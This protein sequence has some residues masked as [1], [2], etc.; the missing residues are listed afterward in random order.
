MESLS[1]GNGF[2]AMSSY[3]IELEQG[4]NVL[5]VGFNRDQQADND[6]IVKDAV[7]RLSELIEAK[8]LQGG[9]L[10]K[11]NGPQSLPVA[12]VIAHKVAHLYG[13]IAVFDPKLSQYVVAITHG[14]PYQVGEC[15]A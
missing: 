9:P 2:T 1:F 13:A 12:F 6:V 3:C 8:T 15:L 5:R 14:S 11:I 7:A 4:N 10:L